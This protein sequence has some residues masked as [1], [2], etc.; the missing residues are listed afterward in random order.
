MSQYIDPYITKLHLKKIRHY[1]Q[2]ETGHISIDHA[3]ELKSADWYIGSQLTA[4]KPVTVYSSPGGVVLRSVPTGGFVGTIYS[5]VNRTDGL[6]WQLDAA[7][8]F[9]KHEPGLFDTKIVK[10][11]ASGPVHEQTILD[12]QKDDPVTETIKNV[13]GSVKDIV[14]G[15]ADTVGG[16][17]KTLSGIGNNF[18]LILIAVLALVATYVFTQSKKVL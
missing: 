5:F 16:I 8:G 15:T 10:E 17:G 6:W 7:K 1:F 9:V 2:D 12:I 14:T 4:K 3:D 18:S 11:T 13:G